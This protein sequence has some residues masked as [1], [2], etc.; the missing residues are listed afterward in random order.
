[1]VTRQIF[2]TIFPPGGALRIASTIYRANMDPRRAYRAGVTQIG[3]FQARSPHTPHY[4]ESVGT[5]RNQKLTIFPAEG[6]GGGGAIAVRHGGLCLESIEVAFR[7]VVSY[8]F[9]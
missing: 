3:Q 1:M 7:N 2:L 9:V 8:I 5:T 4:L 6:A